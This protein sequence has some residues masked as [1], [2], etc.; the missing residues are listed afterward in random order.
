MAGHLMIPYMQDEAKWIEHYRNKA[1]KQTKRKEMTRDFKD[2]TVVK[3]TL[4][5]PTTQSLAQAKSETK[6]EEKDQA[7]WAPIKAPPAFG[8]PNT[9]T[10]TVGGSRTKKRKRSNSS[11]SSRTSSSSSSS[12]TKSSQK[13][14]RETKKAA[15][16]R[17][18]N[19]LGAGRD[20]FHK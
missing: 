14:K 9:S 15:P 6:R 7:V 2:K 10:S 20:I 17:K 3:P 12:N 16:R 13:V 18:K 5:L 11:S 8:T 19:N 1:R 4:V